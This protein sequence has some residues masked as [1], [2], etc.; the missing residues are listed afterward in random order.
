M[1]SCSNALPAFPQGEEEI[2]RRW[3]SV[4]RDATMTVQRTLNVIVA[5]RVRT[6]ISFAKLVDVSDRALSRTRSR[7]LVTIYDMR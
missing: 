5:L 2:G 1:C 6:R 4:A 3:K 7:G